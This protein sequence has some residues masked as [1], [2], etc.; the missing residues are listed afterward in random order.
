MG[1]RVGYRLETPDSDFEISGDETIDDYTD[2]I[3]LIHD[4]GQFEKQNRR[5]ENRTP[6]Q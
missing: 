3:D 4:N 6:Y 2:D 5:T 1:S